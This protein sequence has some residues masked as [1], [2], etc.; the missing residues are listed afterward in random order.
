MGHEPVTTPS[1]T[2]RAIET[3]HADRTQLSRC[4]QALCLLQRG[5]AMGEAREIARTYVTAAGL[6]DG[7][8]QALIDVARRLPTREFPTRSAIYQEGERDD[9][10]CLLLDGTALM[11]RSGVGEVGFVRAGDLFGEAATVWRLARTESVVAL[12]RCEVAYL[13]RGAMDS[14]C[15]RFPPL[16]AWIRATAARRMVEHLF[17]GT[18]FAA[19]PRQHREL[20]LSRMAGRSLDRGQTVLA[21]DHLPGAACVVF[22]GRAN[23]VRKVPGGEVVAELGPG[24]LF[25]ARA[26]V[27]QQPITYSVVAAS[28]LTFFGIRPIDIQALARRDMELRRALL[29]SGARFGAPRPLVG[30]LTPVSSQDLGSM[31]FASVEGSF[32]STIGGG[33]CPHCGYPD[34]DVTCS[35]CGAVL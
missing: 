28:T 15:G 27:T 16:L 2:F 1:P 5:A 12:D 23:A 35:A 24:Q 34:A 7:A 3:F 10:L 33:V 14:L 13:P 30:G 20:L 22:S 6:D 19:M 8:E 29:Q 9:A 25:G 17:A 31:E 4:L 32:T 18:P 21:Q 11:R 26:L